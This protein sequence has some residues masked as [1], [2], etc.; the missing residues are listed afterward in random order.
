MEIRYSPIARQMLL[1]IK[2][3]IQYWFYP[4]PTSS[5]EALSTWRERILDAALITALILSVPALA[6]ALA[7]GIRNQLWPMIFVDMV[8]Y[9]GAWCLFILRSI[10]YKIRSRTAVALVF[11]VGLNV[12]IQAG[13]FSGGPAYL[14][15]AAI[16]AA[17]L[18]GLR[19][20]IIMVVLNSATI[21]LLTVFIKN[22]Y[23]TGDYLFFQSTERVLAAGASYILLN[24][25]SAISAAVL[26]TGLHR[27]TH[28]KT[29][30]ANEL[31]IEKSQLL[32]TR[33]RLD[34]EIVE[35]R[36]LEKALRESE[37]KYHQLAENIDDVI[38]TLDMHLNYTYIS[39]AVERLRGW[40]SKKLI[41]KNID[42]VLNADTL[43]KIRNNFESQM[44]LAKATGTYPPNTIIEIE[45]QK[46]DGTPIWCEVKAS[47]LLG[48]DGKPTSILGVT[49]DI[50]ERIHA[51]QEK[52]RLQEQLA[53]SKKMEALGL[54]AGGV[55]HDLN[56]VLS[57][58][59]GYPDLMLLDM[60]ISHPHYKPVS[61]IRQSGL[62]AAA[63]VH[64]LLTLARR[65]VM[66]AEILN[67]NSSIEEYLQSPEHEQLLSYHSKTTV[68]T[69][70]LPELPNIRG[71]NVHLKKTLMNLVSNAA[72]SQTQGGTIT[73]RTDR[74]YIERPIRGYSN[75]TEGEYAVMTVS[76]QGAGIFKADLPHIFEPFYTKKIMGR[77]GTGLGMAVVWGTVQDHNGY[78]E[79]ASTPGQG[80]TFTLYFPVSHKQLSVYTPP[81]LETYQGH[82]ETILVVD[83]VREQLDIAVSLLARLNYKSIAVSSGEA[84]I[85][86]LLDH[87]VDLLVLDMIMT[88]GI[89]GLDTYRAI[90]THHPGQKA[91]I[92]SGYAETKRV[93]EV[94]RL[95]AGPCVKKPYTIENIGFAIQ[96]ALQPGNTEP[97]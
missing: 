10:Q 97:I 43:Q 5:H 39:P 22:G 65:N 18:I 68:Q 95:G 29:E 75:V 48:E 59:V 17:L 96:Q 15:T 89:D 9:V 86:Y 93:K 50:S 32:E 44:A 52:K 92:A 64:D 1:K 76:D 38:F 73:I 25:V 60:N 87:S 35:R 31:A 84:A 67:L 57:G 16:L 45:L 61:A 4:L 58:I 2:N 69:Q 14:F 28:Q 82:G 8:V 33:R 53:R 63:I 78:I 11:L 51:Q 42:S 20:A 34:V 81:P 70:L 40:D 6:T 74:R 49:R 91:V 26:V 55:A 27:M 71:S 19:A 56:N 72:E 23:L 90:L 36:R 88:P 3:Q 41:G 12:C 80:T 62:K 47:F 85:A 54:L 30:L 83:D 46:K 77:S 21:I 24:A 94:L 7:M 37:L 66:T 13:L 79:V